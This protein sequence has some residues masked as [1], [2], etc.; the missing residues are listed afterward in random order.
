MLESI[1]KSILDM[2]FE[3]SF[4]IIAV[5]LVRILLSKFSKLFRKALWCLV[6]LRLSLPFT[7]KSSLS[8]VPHEST[9]IPE[10]GVPSI[11]NAAAIT[12]N[13]FDWKILIPYAWVIVCVVLLVYALF[14]FIKLKTSISDAVKFKDNIFQ[15]EKVDSPFVFGI[16]KP[17]IY[18]SYDIKGESLDFVLKHENT[19][20]KYFDHITK[21]V[22]FAILC[23][24][25]FNP[26]VWVSYVLFCKDTELACDELVVRNM[27]EDKR[28]SYARAL[29]E[30]GTNK[31]RIT[32]CP[33]AFGEVSIKERVKTAVSYKKIGKVALAVSVILCVSVAV[34][35]MTSPEDTV[36]ELPVNT[37]VSVSETLNYA[38]NEEDTTSVIIEESE[39]PTD[40]V[41]PAVSD[42]PKYEDAADEDSDNRYY[43]ITD[44]EAEKFKKQQENMS[45]L[46]DYAREQE[47]EEFDRKQKMMDLQNNYNNNNNSNSIVWDNTGNPG[48][49]AGHNPPNPYNPSFKNNNWVGWDY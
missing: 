47:M 5:L 21:I 36:I 4:L 39:A 40:E 16:L 30:I 46:Q 9:Y 38:P 33:I 14:G 32:A 3:A 45:I 43:Q 8:L 19:H 42:A 6:A 49:Y 29:Y 18:V 20:I 48:K 31:P 22:G 7:F 28:K 2:S 44:E 13:A 17:R 27:T 25:W 34:C 12:N 15:S 11:D 24:H 26:L 1:F 10:N 35:F 37:E 41:V 23:V